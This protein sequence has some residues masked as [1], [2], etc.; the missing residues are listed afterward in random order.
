MRLVRQ[1]RQ[2]RRV[3]RV[4]VILTAMRKILTSMIIL[5]MAV[6]VLLCGCSS[7]QSIKNQGKSV[8]T[9]RIAAIIPSSNYYWDGVQ[10]GLRSGAE[11][12][13]ADVK[14]TCPRTIYS[15]PQM[16]E[17]IKAATAARVDAIVVQGS[18]DAGYIDALKSASDKGILI[19]FVDTDITGFSHRLYVGTDN[20]AAGRLMAEK[21]IEMGDGKT[22][23]AVLMGDEG[24]PNLD[25]RFEGFCDGIADDGNISL[26]AVERTHFDILETIEKYRS[27]LQEE[28]TVNAIICLDGSGGAAFA[29]AFG[30]S[31][32][33]SARILCFD[34]SPV[35]REAI[36]G[37]II[38]GT[39]T[40]SQI[41]MGEKTI[42]V[43]YEYYSRGQPM[44]DAV[45]TDISF[46]TAAELEDPNSGY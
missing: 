22:K 32:T 18:D 30:P 23:V 39:I 17:M 43:L 3:R 44:S 12:I 28:P 7:P 40:Q 2:A 46:V 13:N 5:L 37:G 34:M 4:V 33:P 29:S 8:E 6:G 27:V 16:T 25:S 19:A 26:I 42:R 10:S 15:I 9:M 24:F 36:K 11:D 14:I 20:Y 35:V 1:A 45:Y 38:S 21:L 31:E 41:E